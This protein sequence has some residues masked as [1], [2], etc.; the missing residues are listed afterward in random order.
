[1]KGGRQMT[2]ARQIAWNGISQEL[3]KLSRR[4]WAEGYTRA[5]INQVLAKLT[6]HINEIL[7]RADFLA[8]APQSDLVN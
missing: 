5:E 8:A 3:L 1:M 7:D 2:E 4:L 6:P